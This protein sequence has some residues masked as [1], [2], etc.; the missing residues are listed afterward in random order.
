MSSRL[1]VI[2]YHAV[3]APPEPDDH[4]GLFVSEES[5][6]EQMAFLAHHRQVVTLETGLSGQLGTRPSVAITFDDGYRNNLTMAAPILNAYGLPATVFVATGWLGRRSDWI[7][8]PDTCDTVIMTRDELAE[9][10]KLGIRVE[11]HGHAHID[12]AQGDPSSVA[13]DVRES[14]L[15][16][17]DAVGRQPTFLAFPWGNHTETARRTVEELGFAGA[18]SIDRPSDGRFAM[19]RTTVS[20]ATGRFTFAFKTSGYFETIRYSRVVSG[21]AARLAQARRRRAGLSV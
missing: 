16:I 17:Q 8:Y 13:D 12:M 10:E 1:S 5:F 11:S 3:G 6:A 2:V 7:D 20:R 14:Q 18:F 21:S 4:Y 19:S 15:V 9:I